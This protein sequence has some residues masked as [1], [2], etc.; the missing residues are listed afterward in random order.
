MFVTAC[1]Y[2]DN[3]YLLDGSREIAPVSLICQTIVTSGPSLSSPKP[4]SRVLHRGRSAAAETEPRHQHI[5][6]GIS[7][8]GGGVPARQGGARR[9]RARHRRTAVVAMRYYARGP[10]RLRW[11][12]AR[13]LL[14]G[15]DFAARCVLP[16]RPW[17]R[18]RGRGEA[19]SHHLLC[20]LPILLGCCLQPAVAADDLCSTALL[21]SETGF[22]F[23]R[24]THMPSLS[25]ATAFSR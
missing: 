11:R 16:G 12:A 19:A 5:R 6:A 2:S 8:A 7:A 13:A 18:Q 1:I 14:L 15:G 10:R 20:Y 24:C 9:Q 4:S 25:L 23:Y 21:N 3:D 22:S 17:P